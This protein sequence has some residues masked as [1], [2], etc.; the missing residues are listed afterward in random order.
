MTIA[1][2]AIWRLFG[3]IFGG[4]LDGIPLEILQSYRQINAHYQAMEE[5]PEIRCDQISQAQVRAYMKEKY[6]HHFSFL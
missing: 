6:K 5:K 2:L 1:D 3:W 4:A